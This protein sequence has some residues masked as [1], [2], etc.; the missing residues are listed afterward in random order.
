MTPV[1]GGT[2]PIGLPEYCRV[3]VSTV[4]SRLYA[5]YRFQDTDRVSI[6]PEDDSTSDDCNDDREKSNRSSRMSVS[7]MKHK[8]GLLTED[9]S[10]ASGY[11]ERVNSVA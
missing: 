7:R 5:E 11:N 3:R 9:Q 10:A 6:V 8:F 2:E 4:S 1:I